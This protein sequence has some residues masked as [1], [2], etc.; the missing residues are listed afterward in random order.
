MV[1]HQIS[2]QLSP[3]G[4]ESKI[5]VLTGNTRMGFPIA[6]FAEE[7]YKILLSLSLAN[8]IHD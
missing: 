4:K 7:E 2:F 1:H 3:N 5:L 6:H 8:L